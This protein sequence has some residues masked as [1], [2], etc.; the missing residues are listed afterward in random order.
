M[1]CRRDSPTTTESRGFI[2]RT[3]EPNGDLR[4]RGS[5][6]NMKALLRFGSAPVQDRPCPE[7]VPAAPH[8]ASARRS[9]RTA[10]PPRRDLWRAGAGTGGRRATRVAACGTL[11]RCCCAPAPR[12]AV[13]GQG[14]R[15][16]PRTP[17]RTRR[18]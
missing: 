4:P 2:R 16:H 6:P 15:S 12:A 14:C 13:W 17:E 1:R 11:R 18:L 3:C 9:W 10:T 5:S 7:P 8:W